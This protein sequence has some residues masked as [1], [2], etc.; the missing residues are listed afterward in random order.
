MMPLDMA[1][2]LDEQIAWL[3]RPSTAA[4]AEPN[5]YVLDMPDMPDACVA[6]YQYGGEAPEQT[7]RNSSLIRNRGYKL[8]SVTSDPMLDSIGLR[9]SMMCSKKSRNST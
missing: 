4:G 1:V 3:I 8:S 7:L 5:F 6:V 2:H 9:K